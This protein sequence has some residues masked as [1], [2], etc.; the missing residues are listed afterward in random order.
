MVVLI[1]ERESV[2]CFS[3]FSPLHRNIGMQVLHTF[4]PFISFGT[5]EENSFNNQNFLGWLSFPLFSRP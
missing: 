1:K 4:F 2:A 3:P 5:D